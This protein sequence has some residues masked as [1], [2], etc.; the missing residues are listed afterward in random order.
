MSRDRELPGRRSRTSIMERFS[1][2]FGAQLGNPRGL[3]GRVIGRVV[4][5]K[6]NASINTWIVQL[7]DI[8]PTD[9]IL[10]AGCGPGLALQGFAARAKEGLVVGIDASPIMVDQARKRNAAEILAGRV[11]IQLGDASRLPYPDASFDKV[12]AVH[13][14]Y[15]WSDAVATLQELR[16]VLQPGGVVAIGFL[17]KKH[18]PRVTQKAFAQTGAT[19]YP[20]EEDVAAL[21]AAAGFTHIR[22]EMQ[23]ASARRPGCCAL[24]QK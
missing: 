23:R 11:E 19:L 22:V 13:V 3:L 8:Q 7:L 15:F 12:V 16:R 17:L 20:V 10:E 2:M 24:G 1:H 18:A 21:L 6:G 5:A 14:I 9:H 4:F